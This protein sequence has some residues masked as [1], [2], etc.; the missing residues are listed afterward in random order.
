[1]C[2]SVYSAFLLLLL[3]LNMVPVTL[4]SLLII[5]SLIRGSGF[6][7]LVIGVESSFLE[8]FYSLPFV[9]MFIFLFIEHKRHEPRFLL[10]V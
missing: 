6:T 1:M 7:H 3:K 2:W 5:G 8:C 10:G 9:R 4:I